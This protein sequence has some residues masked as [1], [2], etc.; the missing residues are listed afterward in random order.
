L[1]L[2]EKL[3]AHINNNNNNKS[4]KKS[5]NHFNYNSQNNIKN[6]TYQKSSSKYKNYQNLMSPKKVGNAC[7][8]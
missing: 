8:I 3:T 5:I 2:T 6:F 7:R 4:P 1:T